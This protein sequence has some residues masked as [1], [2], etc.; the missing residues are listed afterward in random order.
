MGSGGRGGAGQGVGSVGVRG[1]GDSEG[2]GVGVVREG[3]SEGQGVGGGGVRRYGWRG[4]GS[5]GWWGQGCLCGVSRCHSIDRLP[6]LWLLLSIFFEKCLNTV[7][8]DS[9]FKYGKQTHLFH[10]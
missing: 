2:H 5:R 1:V 4:Q 8:F 10:E 9:S 3:D 7:T 6:K